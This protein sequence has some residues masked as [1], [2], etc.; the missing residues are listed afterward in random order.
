[1]KKTFASFFV[2]FSA[3]L[4]AF[5]ASTCETRVDAHQDATTRQRVQYCLTPEQAAPVAP[6]PEVVYYGVSSAKPAD[7][8]TEAEK[9]RK[10]VYFDKDGVAVSQNYVDTSK[11]PAFTND[12]LSEQEKIALEEAQKKQALLQAEQQ[13]KAAQEK[14]ARTMSA[15]QKV[16]LANETKAG[17]LARQT[18]AK[19]YM[20]EVAQ[21]PEPDELAQAYSVTPQANN[22]PDAYN[23]NYTPET[24][25]TQTATS[26]GNDFEADLNAATPAYSADGA[27]PAGFTDP[28]LASDQGFGYNAT[29]PA[30]QQ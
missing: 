29:D 2:L 4:P 16:T 9:Q 17:L 12:T 19:R 24:Y 8:S 18:K 25:S 7:A 21:Q 26:S 28:T 10:Q 23:P 13:A 5:C 6:G 3:A 1:M 22:A 27:A 30:M 11:F 14:P 15:E 20:K